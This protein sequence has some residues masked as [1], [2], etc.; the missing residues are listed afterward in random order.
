MTW[1]FIKHISTYLER[2]KLSE[3]KAPTLWPSSATAIVDGEILGKCRRQSYF[4]FARDS[5]YFDRKY[6]HLEP[7]VD[8]VEANKLPPNKYLRWIWI[9]G[10]LYE[11]YCV[12][13]AKE[14]GVFIAGQTS[15]YIPG[16]NISGKIDLIVINPETTKMHIVEVKSV[17]GFNA[18]SV[19]GTEAQHKKNLIGTPRDSHL[20]QL[21]IYQWWYANNNEE[22]GSGLLT[23]GARDTGR[24]AEYLVTVE[25]GDDDL[26]YIFY[27]GH[28][29]VTTEKVNSGITIQ[30]ILEGYKLVAD[31]VNAETISIP[32]ADFELSY[33]Q[34]K[35]DQLYEQGLLSK[36]DTTQYEKRKK[37]LEEGKKRVVK[38]VEKGDW[39][40]RFC[41]YKN[42]CND[43]EMLK[44]FL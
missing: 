18:N 33:S 32:A 12:N 41:D 20:M 16:Y 21:G 38:A 6:E 42:I 43:K 26:D 19:L 30:S 7:L 31:S 9:Q 39:Q 1:S 10:E 24:Y 13:M 11:E 8:V 15:V 3:Q 14:S 28:T 35:I 17:Y 34:E 22:F 4:R 44:E 27:Q 29:P 40:C 2:P 23:Y 25:K 36:T 37:Q 5:Y